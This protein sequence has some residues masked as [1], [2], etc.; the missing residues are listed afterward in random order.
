MQTATLKKPP[1]SSSTRRQHWLTA[2]LPLGALIF[3]LHNHL[4][5]ASTLI[6]WSWTGYENRMPKGPVPHLHG[7]ITLVVQCAGLLV[8]VVLASFSS[9]SESAQWNSDMNMEI[10]AHPVWLAFGAASTWVMYAYKDWTGYAGGLGLAFWAMSITPMVFQR[11]RALAAGK[12]VRTYTTAFLVYC[13][14]VLASLFT[15][16][17]AF[18]PGGA[19]FRERTNW[20][21]FLVLFSAF[22]VS[23]YLLRASVVFAQTACL[24][25]AFRWSSQNPS[26]QRQPASSTS[27][28][29]T[30]ASLSKAL[31]AL[32]SVLSVLSTLYRTPLGTPPTPYKPGPRIVNMGIWTVHFGI[33]NEGRESQRAI[34]RLIRCVRASLVK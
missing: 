4:A 20:L 15:V 3:T 18:V 6:S 21:V 34:A 31:L 16:A 25:L 14:F 30:S 28:N 19:I 11:T 10:L 12:V 2:S 32:I 23:D 8:P 7:A 17:Y 26:L 5:D 33:D 1:P 24:T 9:L 29:P 27:P 22:G 13:L